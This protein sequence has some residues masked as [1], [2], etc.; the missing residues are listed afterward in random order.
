[1]DTEKTLDELLAADTFDVLDFVRAAILPEDT[2]TL[3]TDYDAGL[4]LT[5]LLAAE[6]KAHKEAEESKKR[7]PA[8]ALSIGDDYPEDHEEEIN[9]LNA[10]IEKSALTFAL[11]GLAPAAKTAIEQNLKAT[12]NYS[13]ADGADNNEF[14][15]AYNLKLIA[16]SIRSVT[17]SA[18]KINDKKWTPEQVK[19]FAESIHPEE[20]VK[21][22][23]AAQQL[24]FTSELFDSR[25]TADFS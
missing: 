16:D 8:E 2:V 10:R 18:G 1:M 13:E 3:F 12:K 17:N 24:T 23:A 21:L 25:V 9:N 22:M 5:R 19:S 4:K 15:E 6:K 20:Y 11:R 14:W 7:N